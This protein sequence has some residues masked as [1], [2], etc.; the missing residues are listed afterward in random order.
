MVSVENCR[1]GIK[2][3]KPYNLRIYRKSY[4][5]IPAIALEFLYIYC[6]LTYCDKSDAPLCELATD[7]SLREYTR[8]RYYSASDKPPV[9]QKDLN[10]I[11]LQFREKLNATTLW[12]TNQVYLFAPTA[13]HITCKGH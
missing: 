4:S 8:Y 3:P 1:A 5:F 6:L 10:L 13:V 2:T 7:V 11:Y 9:L 12:H